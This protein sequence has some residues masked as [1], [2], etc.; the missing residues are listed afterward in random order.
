MQLG[1]I[2]LELRFVGHRAN[3]RM[4]EHILGLPGEPDLID[5]FGRDQ[6]VNDRFDAQRG[7]QVE[8][9]PRADHRRRAQ[10]AFGFRVEPIDARGDGRLQRGGHTHLSSLCRR[11][12]CAAAPRA[13][14]HARPD[15]ARSPRRKTD[16][17]RPCS[18][19]VWPS[20]ADRGVRPEQLGDQCCGLRIA[21]RR[22]GDRLRTVHPRQR[23]LVFGTV[24]D[25]HQRGRLRDHREEI[26]QHRLADLIDPMRVLNDIDRR[27]FAGQ[28]RGIHQRGQPPPTRIGIDL[29]QRNI[30]IG[31]A[32]QVVEQQ[33]ILGVGVGNP[34]A[35]AIAG[36]LP[37]KTLDAEWPRAAAARP[38]G[39]EPGW[40]ATRR[41]R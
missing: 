37:V 12:V 17:R 26:G 38:H 23:P 7:Q 31:D 19:I 30:G 36:G 40:H 25:Q 28:R 39:R 5:E 22:K 29:R 8:A 34:V 14:R 41:R 2:G 10:R 4:V 33:Q 16:Y 35:H 32:Q 13:A 6:V 18:T 21:Q 9:E 3:Q 11:H 20:C 24:G 15:R 1:A 27:G